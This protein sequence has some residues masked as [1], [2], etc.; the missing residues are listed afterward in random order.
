MCTERQKALLNK[1]KVAIA[2]NTKLRPNDPL[3]GADQVEAAI[4]SGVTLKL[5]KAEEI[6]GAYTEDLRVMMAERRNALKDPEALTHPDYPYLMPTLSKETYSLCGLSPEGADRMLTKHNS[7]RERFHKWDDAMCV[8]TWSE[9]LAQRAQNW[10][11][12]LAKSKNGI[13]HHQSTDSSILGGKVPYEV[14]ENIS[15]Q[16]TVFGGPFEPEDPIKDWYS[17]IKLVS[18]GAQTPKRGLGHFYTMICRRAKQVGGGMAKALNGKEV[19]VC[20]YE[21]QTG[22]SETNMY[23]DWEKIDRDKWDAIK[24]MGVD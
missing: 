1:L 23:I 15:Y 18:H 20:H 8:L 12:F 16:S 17:E 22:S 5:D 4:K 2:L 11:E 7:Y 14:L 6:I 19:W 13:R 3:K 10:A 9:K 24:K 21:L